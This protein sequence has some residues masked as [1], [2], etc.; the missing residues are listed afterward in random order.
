MVNITGEF[1][2]EVQPAFKKQIKNLLKEASEKFIEARDL[3][4]EAKKLSSFIDY[5]EELNKDIKR[6]VINK[7]SK[8]LEDY[9]MPTGIEDGQEDV[10]PEKEPINLISGHPIP[11]KRGRKPGPVKKFEGEIRKYSERK[12]KVEYRGVTYIKSKPVDK[13]YRA[14]L[15]I[16]GVAYEIGFF[17]TALEA[18]YEYDEFKYKKT[19]SL[20]GLNFP[21]RIKTRLKKKNILS[22][23]R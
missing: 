7:S 6:I 1:L 19:R 3:I 21:G 13:R 4:T 23:V 8:I 2:E 11:K 16:K 20:N 15:S 18:A 9:T 12:A 14:R 17:P 22:S 5:E 10:V